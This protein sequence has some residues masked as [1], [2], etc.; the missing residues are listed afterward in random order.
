MSDDDALRLSEYIEQAAARG[1]TR[2]PPEPKLCEELGI[3]R[4]RLR[5]LLRRLEEQGRI[6]RHVGKGTFIGSRQAVMDD[7]AWASAISISDIIGARILLEPQLAGQA[8]IHAT[9]ADL[10]A[11][12]QSLVDMAAAGSY[13]EW[14]RQD[15]TLHRAIAVA[16]HNTLLLML[17]DSL[18]LQAQLGLDAKIESVFGQADAPKS[19]T[20]S[21][22][23]AIL[24][25]IAGHD[26]LLAEQRMRSHLQS[27]RARMFAP[28]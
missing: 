8:A 28:R 1:D 20:H 25:A 2:L 7:H 14:K 11:M 6:W 27:V 4:G 3:S 21:E 19:E 17:Y 24:E 5:T 18:R 23:L 16:T 13:L 9:P 10:A 26:P 12:R 22:H 15:E